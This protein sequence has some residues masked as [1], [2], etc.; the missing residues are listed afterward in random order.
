MLSSET[1]S[2]VKQMM[3]KK[4]GLFPFFGGVALT[5]LKFF[6]LLFILF[7]LNELEA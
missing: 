4:G 5:M 7:G 3:F 1:I 2:K 6:L